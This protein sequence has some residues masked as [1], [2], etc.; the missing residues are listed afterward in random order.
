MRKPKIEP[1]AE[2]Y[3]VGYARVSTGEQNLDMQVEALKRYGVKPDDIY[4]EH[5]STRKAK[6]PELDRAI[7]ELREGDLFV[8]WKLDR[9]ARSLRD[10]F[11]RIDAIKDAGASLVSLTEALDFSTPLGKV[12]LSVIGALAELERDLISERTRAGMAAFKE[13]GGKPGRTPSLD[14][15]G[16]EKALKLLNRGTMSK[17]AVAREVGVSPTTINNYFEFQ[18]RKKAWR[19]KS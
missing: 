6:R 16:I 8:V 19:R 1:P 11:E 15:K 9:I 3:K 4:K 7:S 5:V 2:K 10:L 14:E 12:M 17:A 13:R 18:P